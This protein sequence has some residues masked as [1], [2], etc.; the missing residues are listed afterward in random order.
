VFYG[1]FA[2]VMYVD[3]YRSAFGEDVLRNVL[4]KNFVR[5]LRQPVVKGMSKRQVNV[6][7]L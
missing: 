7:A 1:K 3:P 4:V 2:P 5:E 6:V